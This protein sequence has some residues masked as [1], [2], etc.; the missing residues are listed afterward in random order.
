MIKINDI[1]C[2]YNEEVVLKGVSFE[3]NNG[4]HLGIIGPNGSGKTTL[5][6]AMT[7]LLNCFSGTIE[8]LGKDIR[9]MGIKELSKKIAVVT[10]TPS[11]VEDLRVM[12]FVLLGRIPHF[13]WFQIVES[14]RDIEICQECMHLTDTLR[15]KDRLMSELSGGERQLVSIAKAL[16]QEPSIILLDEPISYLDIS[17]QVRILDTITSLI[18]DRGMTAITVLHELNLASE[19]CERLI[20]LDRGTIKMIGTPNEVLQ[21]DVIEEVYNTVV[22]VRQNPIS[23]KPYV[24]V[25]PKVCR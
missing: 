8:I 5:L 23:H 1:Y 15:F 16:A 21:Y 3:V 7:K 4:E 9:Q 19:Y 25:V 17:H 11:F 2:G 10:Q 18:K 13:R 6:K 22:V 20:L 14:K 24:F 12:D